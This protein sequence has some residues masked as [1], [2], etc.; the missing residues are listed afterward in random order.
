MKKYCLILIGI[1]FILLSCKQKKTTKL[2]SIISNNIEIDNCQNDI[3][4]DDLKINLIACGNEVED[5]SLEQIEQNINIDIYKKENKEADENTS[6]KNTYW[7][8]GFKDQTGKLSIQIWDKNLPE[9]YLTSHN[10]NFKIGKEKIKIGD[11]I[12]K[13]KG[14]I[15]DYNYTEKKNE[16]YFLIDYSSISFGIKKGNI[17][18]IGLTGN[19]FY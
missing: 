19:Y 9:F 6:G 2:N 13:L 15:K 8:L 3:Y 1:V 7:N 12:E 5:Y 10:I 17:S 18:S 16:L 11:S 14:I 4:L